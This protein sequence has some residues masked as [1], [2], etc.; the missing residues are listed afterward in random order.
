MCKMFNKY[1]AIIKQYCDAHGLDFEIAKTLP[2]CWGKN[3]IWLQYHDV[4]KGK[5]GLNDETP[6]P[7][8][9][10]IRI[11]DGKVDIQ[12]TEYTERYLK[13]KTA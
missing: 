10:I 13:K 9:L 4:K 7:I 2:Q 12:Q 3:D 8:V 1:S 5:N 6:A 11:I